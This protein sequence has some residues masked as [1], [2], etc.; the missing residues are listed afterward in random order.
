VTKNEFF[1]DKA[2]THITNKSWEKALVFLKKAIKNK[3]DQPDDTYAK[4]AMVYSCLPGNNRWNLSKQEAITYKIRAERFDEHA[5]QALQKSLSFMSDMIQDLWLQKRRSFPD[6]ILDEEP[7]ELSQENL[8]GSTLVPSR[9]ILIDLLP[10]NGRIMEVGTRSGEFA[11]H[12]LD[13]SNPEELHVVDIDMSLFMDQLFTGKEE[14]LI[15]HE[16]DSVLAM[17][18]FE[19]GYFDWIYVDSDNSYE[20]GIRDL[21][22]AKLKVKKG[23][24]IVLN[25]YNMWSPAEIKPFGYMRATN[26]FI[27]RHNLKVQYL[28]IDTTGYHDIAMIN[29]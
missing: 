27:I 16:C 7:L 26:E 24:F 21:E 14:I 15:K 5:K 28:T 6:F 4:L 11:K 8:T 23:G 9:E 2:E 25:G 10:H 12:I 22:A 3:P 29:N 1:L 17:E 18:K 20:N 19:D 13:T